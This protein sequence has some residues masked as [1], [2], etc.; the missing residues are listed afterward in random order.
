MTDFTSKRK[1]FELDF[2][3]ENHAK[4]EKMG[5]S[6]PQE[7]DCDSE[8]NS[9]T[10]S[11]E[12]LKDCEGC[13][14]TVEFLQSNPDFDGYGYEACEYKKCDAVYCPDC[15]E[16]KLKQCDSICK[17][18][19]CL[20]DCFEDAHDDQVHVAIYG[21]DVNDRPCEE[22]G[23]NKDPKD[24]QDCSNKCTRTYIT[25]CGYCKECIHNLPRPLFFSCKKCKKEEICGYCFREHHKNH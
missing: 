14:V 25:I 18:H 6:S 4:K 3:S 24:L 12:E 8:S 17:M 7:S 19:F 16:K 21:C 5:L 15:C 9:D 23:E 20:E 10:E 11:D 1:L 2:T 22:C 13:G